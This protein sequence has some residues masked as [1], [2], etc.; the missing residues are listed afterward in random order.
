MITLL[1][2]TCWNAAFSFSRGHDGP[3]DGHH[4]L[5]ATAIRTAVKPRLEYDWLSRSGPW[6]SSAATGAVD[7]DQTVALLYSVYANKGPLELDGS[8]Y[9][10]LSSQEEFFFVFVFGGFPY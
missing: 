10:I 9:S 5:S 7:H 8:T 4:A 1:C 2:G 6:I 3:I